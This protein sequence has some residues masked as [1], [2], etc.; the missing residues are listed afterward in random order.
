MAAAL[1]RHDRILRLAVERHDGHVFSS[2][3][4]GFGIAFAEPNHAV[5]AALELQATL[6]HERWPGGLALRIR[7]GI[8]AGVAQ[9]RDGDYFGSA[10]NRAARLM[11]LAHGGQVLLS[12]AI[13]ELVRDDL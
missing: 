5:A 10:P 2:G 3:G 9:E 11:A 4:D 13:E 12:L 1:E 6:Q 7:M 8:H